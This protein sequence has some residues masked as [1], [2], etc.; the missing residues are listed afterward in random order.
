[1][2][3]YVL[4]GQMEYTLILKFMNGYIYKQKYYSLLSHQVI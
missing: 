2:I 1:M 3:A 4:C